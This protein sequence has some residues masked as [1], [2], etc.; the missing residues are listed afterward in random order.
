ML[1][2]RV[3]IITGANSGIGFATARHCLSLGAKVMVHGRNAEAVERA[4]ARLGDGAAGI[5]ADLIEASAPSRIVARTLETFG[6]LDGLVNNAADLGRHT[7]DQVSDGEFA[8]MM[9][10]NA[11]APL[12]LVQH[13]VRVMKKQA[14][15]GAIVNIGS[16]NAWCGAHNLLLY[17]MGKGALMTATRNLGDT[18]GSFNIRINQLNVGW[19]LTESE[20]ALQRAEGHGDDWQEHIPTDFIPSGALLPPKTIAAHVAFW[21]SDQSAPVTGQVCDLEQYP[22][23]GR[24]K[25]SQR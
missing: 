24:N 25:L 8:H 19:T 13:A 16:T 14:N 4:V 11:G 12:A 2:D 20:D 5:V 17:S 7:L 18:L 23:I 9:R 3:I 1:K 10:V 6:R 21:L 22:V 15:G